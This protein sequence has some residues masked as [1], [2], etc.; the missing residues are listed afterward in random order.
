VFDLRVLT[1]QERGPLSLGGRL[2]QIV[3][4][5]RQAIATRA[6]QCEGCARCVAECPE[7]AITLVTD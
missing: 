3:H 1:P 6:D 7:E 5:G 4:G 2:R